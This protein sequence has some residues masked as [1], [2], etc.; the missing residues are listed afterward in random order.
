[1]KLYTLDTSGQPV[2]EPDHDTWARWLDN[3]I[4]TD[5]IKVAHDEVGNATVSTIFL[6]HAFEADHPV[7]W[8]TAVL[9]GRLDQVK[10]R[11]A[12]SREQ[13]ETMHANMLARVKASQ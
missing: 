5:G 2:L 13:A 4:A 11:C 10:D 12:G 3:A 8:E 7:L 6:A 1:M 9:G